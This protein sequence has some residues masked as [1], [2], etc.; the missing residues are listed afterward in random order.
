V[1]KEYKS[2]QVTGVTYGQ[3]NSSR[4]SCNFLFPSGGTLSFETSV[5]YSDHEETHKPLQDGK[6]HFPNDD[7]EMT[8]LVSLVK[9]GSSSCLA[10]GCEGSLPRAGGDELP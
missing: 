10:V 9:A 2:R 1:T 7:S 5:V 6:S 4:S 8:T 3:S